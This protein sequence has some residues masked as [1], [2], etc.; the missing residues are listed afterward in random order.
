MKKPVLALAILGVSLLLA[1]SAKAEYALSI[2]Y[3]TPHG[4]RKPH[5]YDVYNRNC[6]HGCKRSH[7]HNKHRVR[8]S[9]PRHYNKHN[10]SRKS[11]IYVSRWPWEKAGTRQE[12]RVQTRET[13][14]FSDIVI[15]S[16]AG[17]SETV[18]MEK[19]ARTGSVFDLSVE[20][21]EALRREGVSRRV[22][23]YMLDTS[24]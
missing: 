13:V 6:G 10:R 16:K 12:T 19:I 14:G 7:K 24:R 11:V 3:G 5:Y 9:N 23:N 2:S 20:E 21:V 1:P 22:I 18:I 15:L 8:Y 4:Y 17:V